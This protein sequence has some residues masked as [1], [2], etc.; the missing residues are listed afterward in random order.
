VKNLEVARML[1]EI[2][3]ILEAQDVE[4]KPRAYRRAAR[5]IEEL[6]EDIVDIWKREELEEIPGVGKNI[7]AK[8]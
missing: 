6:S 2:A 8:I 7:A 4:F 1:Y 5:S 3:D